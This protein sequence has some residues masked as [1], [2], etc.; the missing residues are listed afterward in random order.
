MVTL[1]NPGQED[2]DVPLNAALTDLQ[3]QISTHA[4]ATDPHGAKSYTDATALPKAFITVDDLLAQNPFTVAHRGSGDEFP[5][6][7]LAAYRSAAAAGA[8]AIEVSVQSTAD[9]VLVCF[10]DQ[11]M[12][13]MTGVTG[14]ISDYTYATLR[15]TVTIK[16]QGTL[17]SGWSDQPIPTMREVLDEFLGKVVIFLEPK[18]N[19]A[20]TALQAYL[21][22]FYP[23]APRSVVWKQYYTATTLAWAQAQGFTVWAYMDANTTATQLDAVDANVDI[24]GCPDAS[25]DAQIQMVVA[26]G[27]PVMVWEVHRHSE[28][29]RFTALGVQGLMESGWLYLNSGMTA[30]TADRFADAIAVPGTIGSPEYQAAYALQYDAA[31]AAYINT[32][33]DTAV[34]MG[35]YKTPDTFTIAFSM[36]WDTVPAATLHSDLAFGRVAD[37][38]YAFGSTNDALGGYGSPGG[39]HFVFRGNGDMQLYRHDAGVA[40]GTS[41]GSLASTTP[42]AGQWMTFTIDVGPQFITVTR[43]DVTPNITFTAD[44]ATYRGGYW[45]LSTGSVTSAASKPFWQDITIS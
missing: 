16:A 31:G 15:E 7:T 8:Q 38:P 45:H 1:P 34:L 37:D 42:V 14:A 17:G 43:T 40:S 33:P 28:V 24:W 10:H 21:P 30:L 2:W 5:E 41:L 3:G 29:A 11:D 9:G 25:S 4:G 12:A 27:K 18:T 19:P 44:S 39:Y 22:V 20:V 13:R 36:K 32:V 35:G 23:T 26:R 6:H